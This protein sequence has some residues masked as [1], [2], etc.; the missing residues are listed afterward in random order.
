MRP[1]CFDSDEQF[2]K[3]REM[4]RIVKPR[5]YCSDCTPEYQAEMI[6]Q[7]RCL[8][9]YVVFKVANGFLTGMRIKENK[10]EKG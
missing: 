7:H 5:S 3:W 6:C 2:N 4:A 10:K 9:P 1:L 8:H